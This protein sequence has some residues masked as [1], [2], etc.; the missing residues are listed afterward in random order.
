MSQ[1]EI[2]RRIVE[3]DILGVL[4]RDS[5][6]GVV[7]TSMILALPDVFCRWCCFSS[8]EATSSVTRP[9]INQGTSS[10]T[11]SCEMPLIPAD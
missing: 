2:V 8:I 6:K 7:V 9:G 3:V 11:D 5:V 4:S 1:K 10:W